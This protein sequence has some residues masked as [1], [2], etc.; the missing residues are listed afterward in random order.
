M[1]R[2]SPSAAATNRRTFLRVAAI[3]STW[4]L[5]GGLATLLQGCASP[6][7]GNQPASEP[8]VTGGAAAAPSPAVEI[9]LTASKGSSQILPGAATATW[10]YHG[11][12]VQGDA[13]AVQTIA[14]SY[15]GPILHLRRGQTVGVN[16]KNELDEATIIHW[17]GLV[18]PPEMDGHPQNAVGPGESYLYT[19]EVKNRAGTYWFH[20]HPH[21]RTAYQAYRGLAGLVLITDEE[22]AALALPTGDYDIP[23]VIQDRTFDADN[24]LV[25]LD[26]AAGEMHGMGGMANMEQTMGFLGERILVN[27]RP[28]FVLPVSTRVYRLRLLN[29]SNSRIYKLAWSNG[30]PLNVIA[31][32]GGLLEKPLQ[33]PYVTLSPGERIEL[34]ADFSQLPVGEVITLQSLAFTGVEAGMLMGGMQMEMAHSAVLP[35]GAPF[36]V[37][38]VQVAHAEPESLVL[39][40]TLAP[41]E[42]LRAEEAVNA[43]EPRPFVLGMTGGV[44]TINGKSFGM[45]EVDESETVSFGS[46]E[47]WELINE[48]NTASMMSGGRG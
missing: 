26:G 23:L 35:N 39:P 8:E 17:H 34:W 1:S 36:D 30:A 45:D 33:R 25:Y 5:S 3:G 42:Q 44:W 13:G 29:G 28:D 47:V 48:L 6:T 11:A 38:T 24:Q 37:L 15:L 19:F 9:T 10:G 7:P 32:D 41:M 46:V 16:L 14:D 18:T 12:V 21:E 22:E 27:G 4:F 40:T 31:T 43:N 2:V 20:P